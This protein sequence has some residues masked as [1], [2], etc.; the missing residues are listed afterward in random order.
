MY[1]SCSKRLVDLTR[2]QQGAARLPPA[3]RFLSSLAQAHVM[4]KILGFTE[5]FGPAETLESY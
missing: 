3:A 4:I 1:N 5:T 2:K